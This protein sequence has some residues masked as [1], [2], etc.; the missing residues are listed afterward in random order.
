MLEEQHYQKKAK[1]DA[2]RFRN[3][4]DCGCASIH[5]PVPASP[6]EDCGCGSKDGDQAQSSGRCCGGTPES[7][8]HANP[9]RV[10]ADQAIQIRPAAYHMTFGHWL[11][12][13]LARLG[14]DR[15]G[16]RLAPGLYA[17]GRPTSDSPVLVTANYT[18]SFDA[19]RTSLRGRD[20]YLLVLETYGINVWCAAG[21]GTFGTEEVNRRIH[22]THLETVVRHRRIILPQLGAPGVDAMA[23]RKATGF[24]ADFGPVRAA[25]LPEYLRTG[26]ASPAMRRVR[27]PLWDRIVLIPVEMMPLLIPLLVL[28]LLR[29][30]DVLTAMLA[31]LILFPV[32]LPWMPTAN[33][34]TKGYILGALTAIPF[35]L[36]SLNGSLSMAAWPAIGMASARMLMLPPI[37]AFLA[38][39]F[40][41]STP[42][43]SRTGVR[44]EIQRYI[45]PMAIFF[46]VGVALYL[47]IILLRLLGVGQ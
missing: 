9:D 24:R 43:P 12:H 15:E 46:G 32:L 21:K 27:F 7:N 38:L 1:E 41:G 8:T 35:A 19:L 31:G 42:F 11:D 26:N 2:T 39:N 37:T 45:P 47:V 28:A 36:G 6:G 5:P 40:T 22:A 25:D 14:I 17:L 4:E 13:I 23:V 29:M 20:A 30:T 16:H 34:S 33:Y 10:S 3:P 44:R 18:L